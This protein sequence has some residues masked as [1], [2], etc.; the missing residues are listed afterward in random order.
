MQRTNQTKGNPTHTGAAATQSAAGET[1]SS[2][3]AHVMGPLP[4]PPSL[5]GRR[6]ELIRRGLSGTGGEC[7]AMRVP[8]DRRCRNL[9]VGMEGIDGSR[10][11]EVAV[12]RRRRGA[13]LNLERW[14]RQGLVGARGALCS[15]GVRACRLRSRCHREG[16]GG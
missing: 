14:K 7:R 8:L 3:R 6:R 16:D 15:R 4:P 11:R 2:A 13:A 9:G 10:A 1:A 12:P 5:R